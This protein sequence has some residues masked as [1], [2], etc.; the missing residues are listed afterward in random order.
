[1]SFLC[2]DART[3]PDLRIDSSVVDI[4]KEFVVGFVEEGDLPDWCYENNRFYSIQV[5]VTGVPFCPDCYIDM[6]YSRKDHEDRIDLIDTSTIV[7]REETVHYSDL[8]DYFKDN[9]SFFDFCYECLRHR[10][11]ISADTRGKYR[12]KD[13]RDIEKYIVHHFNLHYGT[14]PAP[15]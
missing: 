12:G 2:L 7:S 10:L 9:C 4:K 8:A 6:L 11:T 15:P 3:D 13:I 14:E 5:T 1:M